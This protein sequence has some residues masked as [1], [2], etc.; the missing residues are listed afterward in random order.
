MEADKSNE[1]IKLSN[2]SCS[3]PTTDA[4]LEWMYKGKSRHEMLHYVCVCFHFN[5]I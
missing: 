3:S 2:T 5:L 1:K 4:K